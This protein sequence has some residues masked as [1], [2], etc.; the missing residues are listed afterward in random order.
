MFGSGNGDLETAMAVCWEPR[1]TTW[2]HK[3][4]CEGKICWRTKVSNMENTFCFKNTIMNVFLR[5][6][7]CIFAGRR[8]EFCFIG[9]KMSSGF[10]PAREFMDTKT[11]NAETNLRILGQEAK[12]KTVLYS[13]ANCP[14]E[15]TLNQCKW[16]A[17]KEHEKHQDY[18]LQYILYLHVIYLHRYRQWNYRHLPKLNH[19]DNCIK[20]SSST[21]GPH[22][23]TSCLTTLS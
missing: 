10:P 23:L 21:M 1:P 18:R 20:L 2:R 16:C 19:A 3:R 15:T 12:M 13:Q 8:R 22:C 7:R 5:K 6:K 4:R 11:K 9:V 17:L 14:Q